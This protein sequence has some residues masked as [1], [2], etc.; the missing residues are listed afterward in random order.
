MNLEVFKAWVTAKLNVTSERGANLVE[1]VFLLVFIALVVVIAVRLL[2][3]SVSNK[4][5]QA[6]N[7][8]N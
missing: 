1:Y 6:S 2:G 3:N 7:Q 5:S 4:F 8:L